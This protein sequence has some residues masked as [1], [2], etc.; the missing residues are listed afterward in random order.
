[1][2][3]Y[4]SFIWV[5]IK[6]KQYDLKIYI[7][8]IYAENLNRIGY[9]N[10]QQTSK[11]K[12][13]K[14]FFQELYY[15][16]ISYIYVIFIH[17]NRLVVNI[18]INNRYILIKNHIINELLILQVLHKCLYYIL[19]ILFF[20]NFKDCYLLFFLFWKWNRNYQSSF[21]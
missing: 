3:F 7:N 1:M 8:Y 6:I 16:Q 20:H 19:L 10:K 18:L 2:F 9:P 17:L 4:N 21:H 14:I 11:D 5:A 12:F 15:M 13:K